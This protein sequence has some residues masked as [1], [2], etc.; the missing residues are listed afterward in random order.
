MVGSSLLDG[1]AP[2][3]AWL[4]DT[5]AV[6]GN[7]YTMKWIEMVMMIMIMIILARGHGLPYVCPYVREGTLFVIILS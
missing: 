4:L 1:Q 6:R 7:D 3:L 2:G 5:I